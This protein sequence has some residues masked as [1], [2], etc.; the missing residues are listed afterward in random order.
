M[1]KALVFVCSI[2]LS[3]VIA[4]FFGILH[5]QFTYTIS[6]ELFKEVFFERF[7]FVEYGRDTPRLTA[8]IIGV[9]T[10]WWIGLYAGLLFAFVGLFSSD[11][12]A[13][14]KSISRAIL[15]MLAVTI[16]TGLLGLC[17][18]F[19]G[20]SNLEEHC[21]FPLKINNVKNL[22][23]A[24]EMHSFSYAGGAI[25]VVLGVAWQIKTLLKM[26]FKKE[27]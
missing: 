25:G 22:I 1:K 15:I 11:A 20:F 10:V 16:F 17:Y 3:I 19:F 7:G 2:F 9:W 4:S 23:A 8:S 18:G 13:M 12:K 6:D 27:N 5:N 21:C 14:I 24:S 26:K